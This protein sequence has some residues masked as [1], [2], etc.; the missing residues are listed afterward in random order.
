MTKSRVN[1][2]KIVYV[3]PTKLKPDPKNPR[4]ISKRQMQALEASIDAEGF[5]VPVVVQKSTNMLIGGHQRVEALLKL[6]REDKKTPPKIP[7]V[8]LDVTDRRAKILNLA[9][10]NIEGEFD[11]DLLSSF[12]RGLQLEAPFVDDEIMVTGFSE[13]DVSALL[14]LSEPEPPG[15]DGVSSFAR[16]VTLTVKFETTQA[17]D[18]VQALLNERVQ[19]D[20][21]K[22][23]QVLRE[24]LS[25]E[26]QKQKPSRK[27]SSV[28][29]SAE[30]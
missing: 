29:A 6:C 8:I 15:N 19:K 25:G 30:A 14:L 17:R 13:Q 20:G 26:T 12:L 23:W 9:L 24:L 2:P 1:I 28:A 7:A 16:S 18:A 27:R 21:K 3:D 4:R 22:P 11:E 10:N 5:V